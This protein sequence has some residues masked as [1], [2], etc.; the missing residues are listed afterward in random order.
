MLMWDVFRPPYSSDIVPSDFW[1]FQRKQHDSANQY[2][3]SYAKI[4]NWLL[5]WI[6]SKVETFFK[7]NFENCPEKW[8]KVVA[9][10][11]RLINMFIYFILK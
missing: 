9:M 3:I 2:F 1:L 4:D 5:A 8:E 6:A 7:I 11:N 10:D